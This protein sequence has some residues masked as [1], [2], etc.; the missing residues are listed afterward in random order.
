MISFTTGVKQSK[1]WYCI[2]IFYKQTKTKVDSSNS[3]PLE[4]T[5]TFHNVI[6]LINS[7]SENNQNHYYYK[8]F[9]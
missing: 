3:L 1:I 6:I 2:C 4:K 8:K 7:V 9:S 5:P